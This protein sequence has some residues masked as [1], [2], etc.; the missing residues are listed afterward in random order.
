[1]KLFSGLCKIH[2]FAKPSEIYVHIHFRLRAQLLW[3]TM[4]NCGS[5]ALEEWHRWL[6]KGGIHPKIEFSM[7]FLKCF[8]AQILSYYKSL[9]KLNSSG[10]TDNRTVS[11]GAAP[12]T[13][14]NG[15]SVKTMIF[16]FVLFI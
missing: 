3:W 15:T 14:N 6:L 13:V 4:T 7:L 1:M 2:F 9:F 11:L 12:Q 16:L 5:I 10:S 8:T